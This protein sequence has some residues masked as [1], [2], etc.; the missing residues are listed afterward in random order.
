VWVRTNPENP[1]YGM[2]EA[3]EPHWSVHT[4]N[5]VAD[6]VW[7]FVRS[8]YRAE[9]AHREPIRLS[10]DAA[11]MGEV[12]IGG[13]EAGDW[14]AGRPVD[15]TAV[16]EWGAVTETGLAVF[17][18]PWQAYIRVDEATGLF[19]FYNDQLTRLAGVNFQFVTSLEEREHLNDEGELAGWRRLCVY[20]WEAHGLWK[21]NQITP[22]FAAASTPNHGLA[23][24]QG[25]ALN[26]PLGVQAANGLAAREPEGYAQITAARIQEFEGYLGQGGKR[27][28]A[29]P[30]QNIPGAESAAAAPP[31]LDYP[32]GRAM[33]FGT[34]GA[35]APNARGGPAQPGVLDEHRSLTGAYH[36]R[37][38]KRVVIAKRTVIP[39]PKPLVRPEDPYG[40]TGTTGYG[41]SGLRNGA[42]TH[43]VVDELLPMNN[44]GGWDLDVRQRDP[45]RRAC[46]LPDALAVAFNWEGLHPFA[47]HTR[48]WT[49][50][51]E[52][53]AGYANQTVPDYKLLGSGQYLRAPVPIFLEVDHRYGFAAYYTAESAV[54]L[55]DDGSVVVYDGWGSELRMMAGGIEARCAGDFVVHAGR[56]FEVRAGSDVVINAQNSLDLVAGSGD[57]RT[58]AGGN[59][60]HL[61]G[62]LGCGG[63]LFESKA[64]CAAYRYTGL[65][66]AVRSSGFA[67]V[68]PKNQISLYA[69]DIVLHHPTSGTDHRIIL[70]GGRYG[71]IETRSA[72]LTTRVSEARVDIAESVAGTAV[73][74]YTPK[75]ALIGVPLYGAAGITA[76]GD[77]TAG[78]VV[79]SKVADAND[80]WVLQSDVFATELDIQARVDALVATNSG[81]TSE[82][83][84]PAAAAGEEF[85]L[86][87][88]VDYKSSGYKFYES[89]WA[90]LAYGAGQTLYAWLEPEVVGLKSLAVTQ[91]YP[92]GAVWAGSSSYTWT[93]QRY[94]GAGGVATNRGADYEIPV[95]GVTVTGSMDSYYRV[96][97]PRPR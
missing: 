46:T 42:V 70:D 18:D 39:N 28:V 75:H 95:E 61:A 43:R 34:V 83:I 86:R 31:T 53:A 59:S 12:P 5:M 78:G 8:G 47:Y 48:D 50:P 97:V 29:L 40:D 91:P 94:V 72:R 23:G 17:M 2:I 66:E 7:P 87:A 19:L 62:N 13:V 90:T 27:V 37:S 71:Q 69:N 74:E 88:D 15:G 84:R 51:Q 3:A 49:A 58:L 10:E 26:D 60:Q 57:L 73:S 22:G 32:G 81:L 55:L 67:V 1:T 80:N 76:Y 38:A 30:A 4:A 64:T 36:L 65:G 44:L 33:F 25:T 77:L 79:A 9:A 93:Y 96:P 85:S 41:A 89:R 82:V 63:F 56:R 16:G 6:G 14:S 45:H 54:C 35:G 11:R 20:P 92:G 24:G 52:S 21:W 68:C